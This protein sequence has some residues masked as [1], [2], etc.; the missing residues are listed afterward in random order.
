MGWGCSI[1]PREVQRGVV[2]RGSVP[3][4]VP[5]PCTK[6]PLNQVLTSWL[7][8]PTL[9]TGLCWAWIPPMT[10]KHPPASRLCPSTS[11]ANAGVNSAGG[12]G[13]LGSLPW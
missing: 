2:A 10:P 6:D 3:H 1:E 8:P 4:S 12:A 5:S 11:S 13:S 9:I 7:S